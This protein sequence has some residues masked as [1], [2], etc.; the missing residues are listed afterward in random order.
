MIG[1]STD[2]KWISLDITAAYWKISIRMMIF[3]YGYE[4]EHSSNPVTR[5]T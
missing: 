5:L 2:T 1:F 3:Q 4:F